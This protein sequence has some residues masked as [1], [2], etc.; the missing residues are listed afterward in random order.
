MVLGASISSRQMM[1]MLSV[2]ASSSAV[3][4][5]YHVFM[6]WIAL[7]DKMTSLNAFLKALAVR[8]IGLTANSGSV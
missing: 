7:L 2:A 8:Y 5:G 4:S 1:Q 6:L 3:A